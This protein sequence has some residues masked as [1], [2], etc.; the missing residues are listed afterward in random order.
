MP[1]FELFRGGLLVGRIDHT[2]DDFP[3]HIG[4]FT[5]AP[6]VED[7]LALFAKEVRLLD[8]GKSNTDEW[9]AVRAELEAP[10]IRLRSV[11]TGHD[12]QRP[13]VHIRGGE[14]TWR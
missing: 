6:D 2:D 4:V 9:R 10:G 3:W 14:A 12:V 7:V 13:L 1:T 5:A 8:S 11:D